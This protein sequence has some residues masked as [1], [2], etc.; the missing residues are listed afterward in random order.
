MVIEAF[1]REFLHLRKLKISVGG[2]AAETFS[3]KGKEN[4]SFKIKPIILSCCV[5]LIHNN[6]GR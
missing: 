5:G 6:N 2:N 1:V 4:G 3:F